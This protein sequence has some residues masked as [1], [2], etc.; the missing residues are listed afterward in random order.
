MKTTILFLVTL[1]ISGFCYGRSW[2]TKHNIQQAD[3]KQ[4]IIH[5]DSYHF[6]VVFLNTE[7][8]GKVAVY[9]SP[10]STSIVTYVQNN[11]ENEDFVIFDLLHKQ[12]SMYYVLAYSGATNQV[13]AIGWI[14]KNN[15]LD[16][17]LKA[18]A[19]NR[20]LVIYRNVNDRERKM[21]SDKERLFTD[22]EI[23]DFENNWLKI[24][25]KYK[26]E[27]YIGWLPP[28]MQC[29]NPYTTCN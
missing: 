13:F 11:I 26:N 9:S 23:M 16:I 5:T 4:I 7:F 29:G 17:N 6:T 10:F 2:D 21:F 27:I 15:H 14:S 19:Y 8:A 18:A 24:K 1:C 3:N 25:F 12:D 22:I 28:E 20:D